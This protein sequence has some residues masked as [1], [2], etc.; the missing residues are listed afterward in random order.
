MT[1]SRKSET[2]TFSASV[3]PIRNSPAF[4]CATVQTA[5]ITFLLPTRKGH[6]QI[7]RWKTLRVSPDGRLLLYEV[8]EGGERT[9]TFELL[10]SQPGSAFPIFSLAG[11]YAVSPSRR[12]AK[13]F[14][15]FTKLWVPN[16][17]STAPHT[18]ISWERSRTRIMSF[19]AGE[20][21]KLR[22]ALFSE[23]KRLVFLVYRFLEK[24]LTDIYLKPL[25]GNEKPKQVFRA[26]DYFLGL[27]LLD[28]RI[29][30]ITD[31][32]A[33]NRRI[34]EIRLGED[35]QHEWIDVVHETD[36]PSEPGSLS[37]IASLFP[38]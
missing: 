19:C 13:V 7:Y 14:T 29:F 25:N 2:A 22:L 34:I 27:R 30:A 21:E 20:D 33:P 5:R 16:G 15:T 4:T 24:T 6:R 1:P 10:K 37:A 3:F 11:I 35:G 9:G 38:I 8:K 23:G 12:T 36:T 32:D 17:L 28:D 31:R 26:I 18:N